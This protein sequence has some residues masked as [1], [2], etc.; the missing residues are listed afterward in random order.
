MSE[1]HAPIGD[2]PPELTLDA[3]L[4][5]APYLKRAK[6]DAMIASALEQAG[7]GGGAAVPNAVEARAGA[8]ERNDVEARAGAHERNDGEARAAEA[9]PKPSGRRWAARTSAAAAL[10]LG[11]LAVGSASAAVL[12]YA[13][14]VMPRASL[15]SQPEK[16]RR[17]RAPRRD[18]PA[19]MPS[20]APAPVLPIAE[21][22][23]QAETPRPEPR[24]AEDWLVEGNRL[25]AEKRWHRADQ[26]Y[27]RAFQGASK[28]QAAYVARVAAAAVRLEHLHDAR[29]ALALYAAALRQAPQGALSEEIRFGIAEAYRQ[30]G[31]SSAERR[32]L[33]S[34]LREHPR[35]ALAAQAKARLE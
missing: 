26:A 34:F 3:Q 9:A 13:R 29:G 31:D 28:S 8:R 7:F 14:E 19:P 5:P 32:A 33:A 35:S 16:A 12:W 22:P 20:V 27:E 6:A 15:P 23:A 25:R 1:E 18:A 24:A 30:L 21:G 17:T 4:G 11:C 10:L 2:W